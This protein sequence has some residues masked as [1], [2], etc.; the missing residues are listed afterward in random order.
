MSLRWAMLS[1]LGLCLA[2]PA[3]ATVLT[4]RA[5]GIVD[6]FQGTTALL[7]LPAS[8]GDTFDLVFSYDDTTIDG[9][10]SF[11]NQGSY[12]I[13]SLVVTIA[14]NSLEFVGP[15]NGQ[16]DIGIQA[17]SINPNLW[18]VDGCLG[19]CNLSDYDSARFNLFYPI[20]TIL[21]D[22]LT[23]PTDPSGANVQFGLFSRESATVE[24]FLIAD[25][26]SITQVPEPAIAGL[27]GTALAVLAGCRVFARAR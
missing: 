25:L 10:P 12:A 22:A 19:A 26:V 18:G 2:A 5:S 3:D 24:A 4:W 20:N 21:S 13:L 8:V 17:N 16:G 1:V 23:N 7:P 27:L 6:S 14:G 15:G 9:V 11:P